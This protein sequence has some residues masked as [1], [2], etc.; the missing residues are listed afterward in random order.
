M[1]DV[2]LDLRIART[3]FGVVLSFAGSAW[4]ENPVRLPA[5]MSF[6]AQESSARWGLYRIAGDGS[7]IRVPT[8][9]EPRQACIASQAGRAVYAA[10]DGSLRL[11]A[12]DSSSESTLAVT[13]RSRSYTQPCLSADG[14][15]IFAVEMAEGKSID[16]EIVRIK[17]A[18]EAPT[19][20]VRQPGAQHEPFLFQGRWLVYANVACAEGCDRLLVEIW[21]RDLLSGSARQLTLL[22][23]LSQNPVTDAKQVVFSSNASG[24]FQL[25]RV[26]LD[27]TELRRLTD[28]VS[29][30]LQ[31]ALCGSTIYFV[32]SGPGGS[33]LIRLEADGTQVPVALP[34][35]GSIRA[36]RCIS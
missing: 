11:V 30:A 23:A 22:N 13:D 24:S 5:H 4:G 15:D 28:G 21:L 27:G 31:P 25:W 36:L 20:L 12:L 14:R 6:I 35:L 19:P 29:N 2:R 1:T 7:P 3:L 18:G 33:G 34:G 26:N 17:A 9:L 32:R 10:A 16:T 8:Q